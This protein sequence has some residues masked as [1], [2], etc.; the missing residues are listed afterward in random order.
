MRQAL[1]CVQTE[2]SW[3][4]AIACGLPCPATYDPPCMNGQANRCLIALLLKL[5]PIVRVETG[6]RRAPTDLQQCLVARAAQCLTGSVVRGPVLIG[7]VMGTLGFAVDWAVVTLN[8]IKFG[9]THTA[10][11]GAGGLILPYLTFVGISVA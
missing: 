2:E 10:I 11:R 6:I 5:Q 8:A 1:S 3:R 9:A 4:W 7:V